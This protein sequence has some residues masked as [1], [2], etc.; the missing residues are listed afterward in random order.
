MAAAEVVGS[1]LGAHRERTDDHAGVGVGTAYRRFADKD[2]LIDAIHAQQVDELEAI[3]NEVLA[4]PDPWEGLVLYLERALQIQAQDLGMAQILSGQHARPEKYDWSRDR[5]APLVEKIAERARLAGVV[6][7]D[8]TGV[9]LILLQVSLTALAK[10]AHGRA[11]SV[12]REDLAE[13]YRR[14]LWVFLDGLRPGR[15]APSELPIPSLT[16][17]Q[18]HIMLGAARPSA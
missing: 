2:E 12:G 14:Y 3:L 9:D 6:R 17:Q 5:L 1:G 15:D 10:V 7:D 4:C 16:T 18:A 8:L 13:L 11:E